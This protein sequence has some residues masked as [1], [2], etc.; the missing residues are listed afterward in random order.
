MIYSLFIFHF[1]YSQTRKFGIVVISVE[2]ISDCFFWFFYVYHGLSSNLWLQ[3]EF[4][5][6]RPPPDFQLSFLLGFSSIEQFP[7]IFNDYWKIWGLFA[8]S[9]Y[10][11]FF[12]KQGKQ[13]E[14]NKLQ[15]RPEIWVKQQF[16][17]KFWYFERIRLRKIN[18][19]FLLKF[20]LPIYH[21]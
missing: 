7:Y 5:C 12:S 4:F 13:T 18:I 17:L 2:I 6:L 9:D 3:T 21:S 16:S 1:F 15:K 10:L 20:A 11:I 19:Y 14:K 8:F